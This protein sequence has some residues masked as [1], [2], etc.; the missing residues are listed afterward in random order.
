MASARGRKIFSPEG[1]VEVRL[2]LSA[3]VRSGRRWAVHSPP[4][5]P[6]APDDE[7]SATLEFARSYSNVS[8]AHSCSTV[9]PAHSYSSVSA[10]SGAMED[11][12]WTTPVAR[13]S[14]LLKPPWSEDHPDDEDLMAIPLIAS[15]LAAVSGTRGVRGSGGEDEA[16]QVFSPSGLLQSRGDPGARPRG[17]HHPLPFQHRLGSRS[18]QPHPQQNSSA[19]NL[20]SSG[21]DSDA[22]MDG[23]TALS[24]AAFLRLDE[25]DE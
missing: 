2:P 21:Y 9:S 14:K 16:R 24:T 3:G 20:N 6:D 11:G 1:D 7:I 19:M 25:T 5:F 18:N 8:A 17:L 4:A 13:K 22:S 15:S 10:V 23:G 12:R